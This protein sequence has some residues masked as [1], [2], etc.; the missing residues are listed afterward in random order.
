VD[1][2]LKQ[3]LAE[4]DPSEGESDPQEKTFRA[5]WTQYHAALERASAV[6]FDDLLV[7]PVRVFQ[8]SAET[9]EK[10][11]RRFPHIL[12][13]E[14]QDT[15]HAQYI[16]AELLAGE[17]GNLFVVGDE[18]Q[19]IYSWRGADIENILGFAETFLGAQ[20][21]RLE[22]NYRSTAPIL[23]AANGVV[24][25]NTARLG[26]RLFTRRS[27]GDKVVL[28][29]APDAEGEAAYVV[30]AIKKRGIAPGEVAVLYRTNGQARLVEE[31]CLRKG[32]PYRIVA[33]VR[34]YA[35]KEI[36][37]ILCYL[38]LAVNPDDDEAF[39]RVINVPPRGIGAVTLERF[40]ADARA[41]GVSLAQAARLCE[42]DP[43]MTV[44]VREGLREFFA[45]RGR[46]ARG[47][48]IH[49]RSRRS[50]RR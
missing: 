31:A 35:R 4:P 38:R 3:D 1:S 21:H 45:A 10:Y 9:L 20:V 15:N 40:A 49:G 12:I 6:D 19:S 22:E 30:D 23:E 11:R 24:A 18:D 48:G 47:R 32:L 50:R 14:Y 41:R 44:R 17:G 26:K 34:F 42:D 27:G 37:D 5:L 39:R 7:L 33:G 16:L 2:R 29:E 25:H 8:Q 43:S 13:D 46:G 36:K 28:F